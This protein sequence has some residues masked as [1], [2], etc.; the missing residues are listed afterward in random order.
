MVQGS[1]AD[2]TFSNPKQIAKHQRRSGRILTSYRS[3]KI[4]PSPPPAEYVFGRGLVVDAARSTGP[5]RC[6]RTRNVII[7]APIKTRSGNVVT[8]VNGICGARACTTCVTRTNNIVYTIIIRYCCAS[9]VGSGRS[10]AH[11]T[12]A[13]AAAF[14]RFAGRT[15]S[16]DRVGA[17]RV[18]FLF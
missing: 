7:C 1:G 9:A 17:T 14:G 15:L 10:A 18:E 4:G 5:R 16:T 13:N 12:R 11:A 8:S 3:E 2:K 6:H